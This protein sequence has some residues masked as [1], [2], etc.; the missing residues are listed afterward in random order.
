MPRKFTRD[1]TARKIGLAIDVVGAYGR[2]VVRGIM[3]YA[4][5]RNWVITVEPRWSFEDAPDV[6]D[7]DVDGVITQVHSKDFQRRVLARRI[8]ATNVSNF[9]AEVKL[10]TVIPDDAAVGAMAADYFRGRGFLEFGF[11]GPWDHGFSI[12]RIG[13]EAARLLDDL[14]DGAPRPA[15]P[16]TIAPSGVVTRQS[17]DVT[18]V[19]DPD[20]LA[21]LNFIREHADQPLRVEDVLEQVPLGRRTLE[22]RFRVAMGRS[23]LSE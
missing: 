23:I 13:F 9:I 6:K 8:T 4:K 17:T 7:W 20:V 14:L 2:G 11:C 22:R 12:V 1:F 3:A 16:I 15:T 18:A 21:A 10:P 19:S 5:P